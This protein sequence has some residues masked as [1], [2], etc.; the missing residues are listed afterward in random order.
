[1]LCEADSIEAKEAALKRQLLVD[2]MKASRPY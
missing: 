1:M 2:R